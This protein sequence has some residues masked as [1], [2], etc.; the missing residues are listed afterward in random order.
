M[1][2]FLIGFRGFIT[3]AVIV[4]AVNTGLLAEE[5]PPPAAQKSAGL[6]LYEGAVAADFNEVTA[7]QLLLTNPTTMTN[8]PLKEIIAKIEELTQLQVQIDE[9]SLNDAGIDL[10]L[11]TVIPDSVFFFTAPSSQNGENSSAT[12]QASQPN[13]PA[14]QPNE[15][16]P[17]PAKPTSWRGKILTR[18][19]FLARGL[20][21][22]R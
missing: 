12:I 1:N 17:Q 3:C 5:S 15:P 6:S 4:G 8:V 13:E 16:P 19:P 7:S 11:E 21:H 20:T 14:S 10:S 18:F 22:D 2:T 9:Q